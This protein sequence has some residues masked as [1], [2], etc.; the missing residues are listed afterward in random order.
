M[1]NDPSYQNLWGLNNTGQT[2]GTVDA[3]IDA[4]EAWETT[5]R[6]AG[7]VVAVIDEGIDVNHPDLRNNLWTN[8]GETPGNRVDDDKNGYIDDVN[9]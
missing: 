8:P 5:T 3:D 6:S 2:R 4:P 9:G 1:P 7:T